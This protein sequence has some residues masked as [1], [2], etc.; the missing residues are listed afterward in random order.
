MGF[1][2]EVVGGGAGVEVVGVEV[3]LSGLRAGVLGLR[4]GLRSWAGLRS[5]WEAREV[6]TG[7]LVGLL[8]KMEGRGEIMRGD[9]RC[10]CGLRLGVCGFVKGELYVLR[11]VSIYVPS[12]LAG[13]RYAH[14]IV[15]FFLLFLIAHAHC[16]VFN[17]CL[18][19]IFRDF[20]LLCLWSDRAVEI[21]VVFLHDEEI[22]L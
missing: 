5:S 13:D 2:E 18:S 10:C 16:L 4:G 12:S 7:R 1:A 15:L 22:V 14:I 21:V 8:G 17:I 9:L 6:G 11:N 19:A 3:G 20:L